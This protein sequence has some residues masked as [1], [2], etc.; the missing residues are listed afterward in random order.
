MGIM[1]AAGQ[2]RE[3]AVEIFTELRQEGI[4]ASISEMLRKRNSFTSRS[5]KVWLARS[6]RPLA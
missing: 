1:G 6:I 2:N 4:P 5:C 3:A